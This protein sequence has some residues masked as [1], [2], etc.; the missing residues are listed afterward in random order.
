[1]GGKGVGR[2]EGLG[3]FIM[4]WFKPAY[5]NHAFHKDKKFS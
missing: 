4:W 3:D 2:G 1:M 5:E